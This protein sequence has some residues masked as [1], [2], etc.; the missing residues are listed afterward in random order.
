MNDILSKSKSE[1][2]QEK[3]V[4]EV[5]VSIK[6]K[7]AAEKENA[8]DEVPALSDLADFIKGTETM[9]PLAILGIFIM[10]AI[11]FIYF[12]K[13]FLMP[14]VW[15][16]LLTFLLKPVVRGLAKI[17]IPE[18]VGAIIVMVI[19]L[20]LLSLAISNLVDPAKE[21]AAK[22]PES[23]RKVEKKLRSFT[24]G[25]LQIFPTVKGEV[26]KLASSEE[27]VPKVEVTNSNLKGVVSF[28]GIFLG[29][30]LE[31]IVLLYFLLAAGD[32]FLHKLVRILPSLQN[33]KKA[34]EI[35]NELQENI[36]VFL[37]TIT[38]INICLGALVGLAVMWVGMPNPV[39]W[40]VVAGALNFIPYF[41]PI[42]GVAVLAIVGLVTFD[43]LGQALLSPIIYLS[44]HAVESNFVTPMILGR[45]LTLNP[46]VIFIS[47]IFWTWI[48]GIP[49]ALLS[50]PM[51]M[52]LKIF[53]DHFKP[54]API[55]EF[56]SGAVPSLTNEI[57]EPA[58]SS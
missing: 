35:T 18:S 9:V 12:A 29:G 7:T 34:V 1:T 46:V 56:L 8:L 50:V 54:L 43:S 5:D 14:V 4:E 10:G 25:F 57:A 33:K 20:T 19:F 3:I 21:W 41:G 23:I 48:W 55:G 38:C 39:L 52:M 37:F 2:S 47:L 51:L 17:K 32:L 49:G 42:T 13:S 11:G 31:T 36:S 30:V 58:A 40:G 24:P 15:A 27:P 28:A 53:C 45:R 26:N 22:A 44:L 6:T 16:V